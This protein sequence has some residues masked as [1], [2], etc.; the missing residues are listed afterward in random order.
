MQVWFSF[1]I[2][3]RISLDLLEIAR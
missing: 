1:K 3:A 2:N